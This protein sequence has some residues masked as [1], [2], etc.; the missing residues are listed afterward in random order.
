MIEDRTPVLREIRVHGVSGTTPEELLDLES[1]DDVTRIAGDDTTGFW[2]RTPEGEAKLPTWMRP[3]RLDGMRW[4]VE[5]YSWGAL[6]SGARGSL[7]RAGWLLLTPFALANIASWAR[8][9]LALPGKDSFSSFRPNP[10]AALVIRLSALSLTLLLVAGAAMVSIDLVAFQCF[11][12]GDLLCPSLPSQAHF[13]A[14]V[15]W[16]TPGRRIA[17]GAVGP[18]LALAVVWWLGRATAQRYEDV[19]DRSEGTDTASQAGRSTAT[20]PHLLEA[21]AMWN[22]RGR[23]RWLSSVHLLGGL[24]VVLVLTG[25]SIR[26]ITGDGDDPGGVG[27]VAGGLLLL[28]AAVG[29]AVASDGPEAEGPRKRRHIPPPGERACA[30]AQTAHRCRG[31]GNDRL[32]G[33][34]WVVR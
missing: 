19:P 8:P 6:T 11:R 26:Q 2:R 25:S 28:V 22:G 3:Q 21:T 1:A 27:V 23:W 20:Y 33:L 4:E 18:L 12:G 9:A 14:D 31:A 24:G 34:G 7:S 16:E 10:S 29:A 30:R 17:I 13:L 5:A 15:G 32:P